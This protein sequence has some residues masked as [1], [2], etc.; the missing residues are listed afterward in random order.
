MFRSSSPVGSVCASRRSEG[1]ENENGVQKIFEALHQWRACE[2]EHAGG[3]S[4]VVPLW[5]KTTSDQ[6]LELP[7][8]QH[9]IPQALALLLWWMR[10]GLRAPAGLYGPKQRHGRVSACESRFQD[11]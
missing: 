5:Q 1:C 6:H 4:L 10:E 7:V 8:G 11:G 3:R 9:D 2:R